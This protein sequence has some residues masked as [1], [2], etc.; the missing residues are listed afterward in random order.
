MEHGQKF[1]CSEKC[2]QMGIIR[3]RSIISK[4]AMCGEPFFASK[5]DVARGM[6]KFCSMRCNGHSKSMAVN[7]PTPNSRAKG[8]RRKDLENRY[9]RSAWEANY[10]RYMNWLIS[11]G[12]SQIISWEFEPKV[13]IFPVKRGNTS[14]TPDFKVHKKDGTYEWH[15][16]KGW[17]DTNSKVKLKR[18]AKFFPEENVVIVGRKEYTAIAKQ[19]K[20]FVPGWEFDVKK[21]I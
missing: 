15:E 9:F 11:T 7:N 16:V 5:Y 10:A 17:M 6:G 2:S 19:V 14:Y 8:G 12:G 3:S 1:Y 20:G 4:C 21:S 18:M 13:F